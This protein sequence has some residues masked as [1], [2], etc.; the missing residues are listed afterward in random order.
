MGLD[1]IPAQIN[2]DEWREVYLESLQLLSAYPFVRLTEEWVNGLPRLI[3][4]STPEENPSDENKRH[5]RVSGDS[6]TKKTGET[7][8]LYCDLTRYIRDTNFVKG[9]E[10]D[11]LFEE[12]KDD[13]TVRTIFS[14]K[15]QGYDYHTY[16]LAIAMLIESR[17]PYSVIASGNFD[18]YQAEVAKKWADEIL[19]KPI[20]IPVRVDAERLVQRLSVQLRGVDAIEAFY[21]LYL[22]GYNNAKIHRVV[23]DEFGIEALKKWFVAQL[24]EYN[25]PGQ[26]GVIKL[27]VEWLNTTQ[28]FD[29]LCAMICCTADNKQLFDTT[30]FIEAICSSWVLIPPE[31]HEFMNVL[32]YS[33]GIPESV[34]GQF[35]SI[36]LDMYFT[37][38]HIE[39]YMTRDKIIEILVRYFDL[40]SEAINQIMDKEIDE[41]KQELSALREKLSPI[42]DS[43]ESKEAMSNDD[44]LYLYYSDETV[45]TDNKKIY[46]VALAHN[47][48]KKL[49]ESKES[50]PIELLGDMHKSIAIMAYSHRIALTEEAWNRIDHEQNEDVLKI[51]FSFLIISSNTKK[52]YDLR[53]AVLENNLLCHKISELIKDPELV[54]KVE[55]M[56]N[57]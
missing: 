6:I 33:P 57:Y 23:M 50:L 3:Y 11:I 25:S 20:S 14:S 38:R 56:I 13:S 29:A 51:L 8:D 43:L 53:K 4:S 24:L 41:I 17:F 31:W 28:D 48:V 54:K 5:W 21:N 26:V 52:F 19:D 32:S 49:N 46:L 2:P 37:G 44:D 55:E 39:F 7:F 10:K 30:E 22:P 45:L 15:T 36:F 47:L 16:I 34:E 18:I 9:M 35:G 42:I 40:S 12:L 1:V 27:F